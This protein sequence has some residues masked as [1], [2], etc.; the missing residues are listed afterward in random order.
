MKVIALPII[1]S[2]AEWNGTRHSSMSARGV[3]GAADRKERPPFFDQNFGLLSAHR[4]TGQKFAFSGRQR[5]IHREHPVFCGTKHTVLTP[6]HNPYRRRYHAFG[7]AQDTSNRTQFAPKKHFF[8]SVHLRFSETSQIG[9]FIFKLLSVSSNKTEQ[10]QI[11]SQSFAKGCG[12]HFTTLPGG[13][14]AKIHQVP[15]YV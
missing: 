1:L 2:Y 9:L 6:P 11:L 4:S 14:Y 10:F 12:F 8:D 15:G 5:P 13:F 7:P 3:G